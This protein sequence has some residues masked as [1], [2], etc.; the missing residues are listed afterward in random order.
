MVKKWLVLERIHIAINNYY[1][2]ANQ[3]RKMARDK[4]IKQ[5]NKSDGYYEAIKDMERNFRPIIKRLP[6][7]QGMIEQKDNYENIHY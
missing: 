5:N 6:P 3:L 7:P 1:R 4:F 2:V